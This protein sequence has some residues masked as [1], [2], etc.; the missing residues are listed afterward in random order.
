M[1][2][3]V[4]DGSRRMKGEV[5]VQ[6]SKNS[7]LP[8]LAATLLSGEESILYNCPDLSDVR[9]TINI[10]R[11]LGCRVEFAGNTLI[12]DSR[13]LHENSIPN[14]LMREMRSSIIFLGALIARTGS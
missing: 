9:G 11:Y 7:V 4:I 8:I 14:S 5:S 13:P 10:L 12:C 6:G 3:L 1:S 2:R